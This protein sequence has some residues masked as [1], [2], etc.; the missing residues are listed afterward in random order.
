MKIDDGYPPDNKVPAIRRP[1]ISQLEELH[2]A[3]AYATG[4][5]Q[6]DL[7]GWQQQKKRKGRHPLPRT[8]DDI[9]DTHG[10][11]DG[12]VTPSVRGV[13]ENLIATIGDLRDELDQAQRRI[14]Y[15]VE[16]RDHDPDSGCLTQRA[17]QAALEHVLV[18]DQQNNVCSALGLIAIPQWMGAR[19][20]RGHEEAEAIAA[21]TGRLL[22]AAAGSGDLVGHLGDA[23]FG[24]LLVAMSGKEAQAHLEEMVAHLESDP[25]VWRNDRLDLETIPVVHDLAGGGDARQ[26]LAGADDLLCQGWRAFLARNA[27]GHAGP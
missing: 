8:V 17:F 25:F 19:V 11:T 2:R 20:A 22:Q 21:H 1:G 6:P 4:E 5:R 23:V 16:Q 10:L 14:D 24:V 26:Q 15:L 12:D 3:R 13:L 18:L 27:P 7:T 9:A